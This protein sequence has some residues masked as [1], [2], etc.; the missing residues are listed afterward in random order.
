M[1]RPLIGI[2]L[3]IRKG[4]LRKG[5]QILL[6]KRLGKH[7]PNTWSFPGGHLEMWEDFETAAIRELHEEAGNI[8]V[9]P[10][11]FFT[12]SNTRFSNEGKHYVVLFMICDWISGEPQVMEPEKCEKWDWFT[13]DNLPSP[14]MMGIQDIKD[15]GLLKLAIRIAANQ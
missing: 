5:N 6:Q 7:S 15:R 11:V 4:D 1:D 9:T 8:A 14:L 10:P 3:I 13:Y 2:G 12:V